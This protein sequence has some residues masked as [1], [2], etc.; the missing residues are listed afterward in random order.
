[1]RI[2]MIED[3]R[4]LCASVRF[5]LEQQGY[6]VDT[7]HDGDEGLAFAMLGMYE[8]ILLDRMLPSIDGLQILRQLRN[9]GGMTP[10]I[11]LTALG[12]LS[13]RVAGLENGADDYLVKPFAMEEL[14]ARIRSI[15]R[16]PHRWEGGTAIELSG[17][18]FDREQKVLTNQG[19]SCS[20]SKREADLL[21]FFLRN[22]HQTLPRHTLLSKIWGLDGEVED[23][24]LDNYIHF[25]RRRLKSVNSPLSLQTIRGIGYRLG[26]GG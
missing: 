15:C 1:M 20:L 25:L 22:P 3:D 11:L 14:L 2:L 12:E 26:N 21:E 13:D 10:V 6:E 5:Q 7:S 17:L 9:K 24:N 16:R 8:V 19:L 4:E 23:G 18:S